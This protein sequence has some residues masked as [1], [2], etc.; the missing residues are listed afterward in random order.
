M[1][2]EMA[3]NFFFFGGG[4]GLP[5]LTVPFPPFHGLVLLVIHVGPIGGMTGVLNNSILRV[6]P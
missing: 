4:G 2:R 6:W 3:R 5:P 1:H